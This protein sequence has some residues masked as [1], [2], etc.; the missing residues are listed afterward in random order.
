MQT[1][2]RLRVVL[3]CTVRGLVG[4]RDLVDE[5]CVVSRTGLWMSHKNLTQ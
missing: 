1:P 3:V 4:R 2:R 5:V